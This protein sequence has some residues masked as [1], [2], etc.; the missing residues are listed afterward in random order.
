MSHD[1][2]MA[3]ESDFL[4]KTI[5]QNRRKAT[6]NSWKTFYLRDNHL[7]LSHFDE[8]WIFRWQIMWLKENGKELLSLLIGTFSHRYVFFKLFHSVWLLLLLHFQI[9]SV[10][11]GFFFGL[12]M[13]FEWIKISNSKKQ[14]RKIKTRRNKLNWSFAKMMRFDLQMKFFVANEVPMSVFI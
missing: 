7:C 3:L 8:G 12:I 14:N 13:P 2:A 5:R 11:I 4:I 10:F 6:K 1:L 9:V